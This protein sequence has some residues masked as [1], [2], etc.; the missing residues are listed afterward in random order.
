ML[1]K[2]GQ[3]RDHRRAVGDELLQGQP[4]I[5][6][7]GSLVRQGAMGDQYHIDLA[8]HPEAVGEHSRVLGKMR[9]IH[10]VQGDGPGPAPLEIGR[11]DLQPVGTACHQ[12]EIAALRSP[13]T[14][15]SMGN[16][17]GSSDDQNSFHGRTRFQ[18]RDIR[19][20]SRRASSRS[21]A[22]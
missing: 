16:G 11:R 4:D 9:G 19:D 8:E 20:G 22:G 5:L 14:G 15:A 18:K 21:Q 12:K 13:E 1:G 10:F 7:A 6:L 17:R 2:Q 3:Q